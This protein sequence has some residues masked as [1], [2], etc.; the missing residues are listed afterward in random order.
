MWRWA[1]IPLLLLAK[2][3]PSPKYYCV[4]K[5]TGWAAVEQFDS[6]EPNYIGGTVWRTEAKC[7]AFLETIR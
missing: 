5:L 1:L 2:P 4:E 7:L 3:D 6:E